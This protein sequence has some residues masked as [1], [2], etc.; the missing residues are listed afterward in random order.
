MR[1]L[2]VNAAPDAIGYYEK[3]GRQRF[4]WDETELSGIAA[5][6]IQMTKSLVNQC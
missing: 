5:G 3:L 4:S 1:R 6:A 2:F